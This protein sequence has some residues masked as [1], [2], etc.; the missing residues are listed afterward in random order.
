MLSTELILKIRLLSHHSN[1]SIQYD[2]IT[3]RITESYQM[4][5]E[6][7]DVVYFDCNRIQRISIRL[8]KAQLINT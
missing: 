2:S 6:P 4:E 5:R 7:L 3:K 1:V 8:T